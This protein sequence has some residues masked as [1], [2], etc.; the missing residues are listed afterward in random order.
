MQ[1]VC[2]PA[3]GS[4]AGRR[5]GG[6]LLRR[7]VVRQA[8]DDFDEVVLGIEVLGAAVGQ[9]GV[10]EGVVR[11]RFN[12]AEKH[13][14]LHAE[15]GGP[16]HIF[17]EVGVDLKDSLAE[18]VAD[19][20]PLVEGIAEGLADVAGRELAFVV[21]EN[22]LMEFV[23]NGQAAAAP[24]EFAAGGRSGSLAGLL[25]DLI[26]F[27]D[28]EEDGQCDFR[29][30]RAEIGELAPG[31]GEASAVPEAEFPGY[32]IVNAVAIGV[33]FSFVSNCVS[34]F[35]IAEHFEQALGSAT[36]VPV[37]VTDAC[38]GIAIGP[39]TTL[40]DGAVAGILIVDGSFIDFERFG[41]EDLGLDG[42][43]DRLQMPGGRVG[44][45]VEG[46]S[47]DVDV[48]SSSSGLALTTSGMISSS[49]ITLRFL[50]K[51]SALVLRFLFAA[52]VFLSSAAD[53][54]PAS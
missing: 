23:G 32:C 25:F 8:L 4:D 45:G 42:F 1:L 30:G 31:V 46:L 10:D 39:E 21:S 3:L 24:D 14:I 15:F 7:C 12:T 27:L 35:V 13:P 44:P 29:R 51:R 17:D 36:G 43:V 20:L 28:V 37:E 6:G 48:V 47:P 54:S 26:D 52:F 16:D 11:S 22:E 41:M 9:K 50:G 53:D 33:D 34:D 19:F 40:P 2:G 38:G 49:M 18:A 5:Q